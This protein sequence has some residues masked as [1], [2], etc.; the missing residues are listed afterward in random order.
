MTITHYV[1]LDVHKDTIAIA[2]A[3]TNTRTDPVFIGTTE[4][5]PGKVKKAVSKL[6]S[7]ASIRIC[8]EAGPCGYG[9]AGG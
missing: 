4:F 1:G 3:H 9:L 8:F 7:P 6:A 2:Y 5:S